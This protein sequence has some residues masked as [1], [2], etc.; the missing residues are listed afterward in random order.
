MFLPIVTCD[1]ILSVKIMLIL[2]EAYPV[3]MAVDS[4][5]YLW[6][7]LGH[8]LNSLNIDKLYLDLQYMGCVRS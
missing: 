8:C 4:D 2:E 1:K 6:V 3:A 7:V 5:R